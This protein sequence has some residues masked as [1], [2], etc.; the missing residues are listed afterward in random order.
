MVG[1]PKTQIFI[2]I[3]IIEISSNRFSP[4]T[5]GGY[6]V[7]AAIFHSTRSLLCTIYQSRKKELDHTISRNQ[8]SWLNFK[9]SIHKRT[10]MQENGTQSLS[11]YNHDA[12]DNDFRICDL[13]S[14]EV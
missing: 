12:K 6:L 9:N 14:K 3:N 11:K 10:V 8:H 4:I 13:T 1:L 7:P 2:S 5:R